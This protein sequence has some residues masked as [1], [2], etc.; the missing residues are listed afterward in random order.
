MAVRWQ[1][2][3]AK[4]GTPVGG[5]HDGTEYLEEHTLIYDTSFLNS[6]YTDKDEYIIYDPVLTREANQAGLF[7]CNIPP[8][9]NG[10]DSFST[11]GENVSG[12]LDTYVSVYRDGDPIWQG[13]ITEIT[14]DFNKNKHIYAEGDMALYNDFQ[15]R[16]DWSKYITY[17]EETNTY[18]N[19][20]ARFF[21]DMAQIPTDLPY[22]TEGKMISPSI[23][24]GDAEF[25]LI[26]TNTV[27]SNVDDTV[28][29][30]RWDALTDSLLNGMMENQKNCTYIYIT[31]ERTSSSAIIF[32]R[33]LNL[34]ILNT[35]GSVWYGEAPLTQQT[36][37]YGKNL[38]DLSVSFTGNGIYT[39]IHIYGYTTKGWWIFKS[40]SE[41][42]T[43]V[44]N[45]PL[46]AQYGWI[47]KTLS[48]DGE[49]ST[50]ESLTEMATNELNTVN[51]SAVVEVEITIKA[52]DLAY[53]GD[54]TDHLDFMKR[55]HIISEP[56]GIDGIYLCTKTVEHLDDP[57]QN[58]YTFGRTTNTLSTRQASSGR[59]TDKSYDI[60]TTTK[61][62]VTDS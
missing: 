35:D 33:I 11:Y 27:T 61:S 36:I 20:I 21:S 22:G 55:T 62:Y 60:S 56:H 4:L 42:D 49:S 54:E 7:E 10:Y 37:E 51:N 50:I 47:E 41:I 30:S 16:V 48:V 39:A 58:E 13:R 25:P 57:S 40:T 5:D 43:T 59:K 53:T 29:M 24:W 3:L 46:I 17:I 19:D 44:Y 18:Q 26:T 1:V 38:S 23:V 14:I 28:Y 32:K 15:V 9:N 45:L 6:E 8:Y 34:L 2:Y 52:I 12:I 31:R